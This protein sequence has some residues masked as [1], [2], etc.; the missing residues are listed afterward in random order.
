MNFSYERGYKAVTKRLILPFRW[1]YLGLEEHE[2]VVE[3]AGEE[4]ERPTAWWSVVERGGVA[5]ARRR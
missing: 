5:L 4:Q 3:E 2:D 1:R